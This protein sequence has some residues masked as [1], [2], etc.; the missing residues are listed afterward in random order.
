[1]PRK[2]AH[3]R[4]AVILTALDVETRAVLRHLKR[5][6]EK[7][8]DGTVFYLGRFE[9]WDIASAECGVGNTSAAAIAE[10]AIAN[11][12]PSVALFVGVAGGV[13]DVDIGDVV[14]ADKMFGYESGKDDETGFRPRPEVKNAAHDIEQRGRTL[15][16]SDDWKK[17]LNPELEHKSPKV[18]IGPIAGGE[19]VVASTLSATAEFLQKHY[20]D[21]LA[22]EME[23]RGFLEAVNIN[24]LVLGGVVRG[25]SDLLS[26]KDQADKS[27]SQAVAADTA[28]AAAFEI[29][30]GLT[31]TTRSKEPKTAP[32]PDKT[33]PKRPGRKPAASK[34]T[35]EPAVTNSPAMPIF[36]ETPTT[37]SKSVYFR[38]DEVLARIGVPNVDELLF[39][40]FTSPDAFLRIIP[41]K[42]LDAPLPLPDLREA[43]SQAPMLKKRPGALVS[44]NEY[45][46]LAYDPARTHTGG[47]APLNWATQLFPNGELWAM[48][49]TMIIRERGGRPEWLPIP[50][51][52]TFVFE[53][54]FY[55]TTHAAVGFASAHLRLTL[56][57]HIEFGLLN[58]K[59]MRLGITT[60]DIRGPLHAEDAICRLVLPSPDR[61]GINAALLQFFEQVY[62][63]SGF[64]RPTA[65]YGFPPGPPR[66]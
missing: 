63:L 21:A 66:P 28:S 15:P 60:D 48:S 4:S 43:A 20:S 2:A 7:T 12:R 45:G 8:I 34:K 41:I 27:G 58:T 33:T 13:K 32:K 30:H 22:I 17:R 56:P 24:S 16:K 46:I 29:L 14:V 31:S 50:L 38:Q 5:N 62:G 52:P 36:A 10:R 1:V 6:G 42:P 65:H 26:H 61:D 55:N 54:L 57:C 64:R 19:R 47:P 3:R 40:Y 39:S 53:E 44:L 11:F 51:L 37:F 59:G 35:A 49:N 9:N 23:G 18:F 25:I